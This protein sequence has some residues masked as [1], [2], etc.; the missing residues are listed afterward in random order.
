MLQTYV[1]LLRLARRAI[2][3][4]FS[5]GGIA[6]CSDGTAVSVHGVNYTAQAFSYQLLKPGSEIAEVGETISPFSAGGIVCC[7]VLPDKWRPD[8]KVRVRTTVWEKDVQGELIEK[9]AL[10]DIQVPRFQNGEPGELWVLRH[11][12]GDFSLVS[13]DFQPNSPKWP[14]SIRGWPVPS[15]AYQQERWDLLIKHEEGY[16]ELANEL[17]Q[18]LSSNPEK[19]A[20]EAWEFAEKN[21]PNEYKAYSGPEDPR[22]R[23]KLKV[24]YESMLK[25]RTAKLMQLKKERP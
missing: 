7:Y 8:L 22:F 9:V 11:P 6:A 12:R 5:V 3:V 21:G 23:A 25:D 20:R 24:E 4:V 14:G 13:S 18:E 17:I 2:I 10:S 1:E 19:R 16:V 15:L